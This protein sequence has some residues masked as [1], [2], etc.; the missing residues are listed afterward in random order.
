MEE[1][2][3]ILKKYT[4]DSEVANALKGASFTAFTKDGTYNLLF[5]IQ[6]LEM[7][8]S[9]I[10]SLSQGLN[11]SK[12]FGSRT[13]DVSEE[14]PFQ[15]DSV[16]WIASLTKLFTAVACMIAVEQKLIGL[17]DNV[18]DIVPELKTLDLLLGFEESAKRPRKPI[19]KKVTAPITLR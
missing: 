7:K 17:D 5:R 3:R 2:D 15:M 16:Q 1:L 19:L 4:S 12:S 10:K 11:Y 13:I 9:L 6:A 8:S 14:K 18:R